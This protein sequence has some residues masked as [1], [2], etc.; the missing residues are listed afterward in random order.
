M[1]I[2]NCIIGHFGFGKNLLNGQ[3][4]K[5]KMITEQ[6]KKNFGAENTTLL[7]LAGG[8]K[9]IPFFLYILPKVMKQNDNIVIMPVENGLMFLTPLLSILNCHRKKKIHYVVIGGWLPTFLHRQKWLIVG[10][11]KFYAIYVETQTMKSM[12]EE[13]GFNNIYVLPNSKDLKALKPE[14][15]IYPNG[16]PYR[17]CTFSRVM[18]EKGIET[19]IHAL[20]HVN[21][22]LGYEA[23]SLDIYGQVWEEETD[24]FEN[25]KESLPR[26]VKYRGC[27]DAEKSVDIL[28]TYFALLF[29]THFF[30]E[31]IP[32][33]ILDAYSAGIP[34]ISAR[35]ES[36]NDVVDEGI[37]GIGYEFNS[38]EDLENKLLLIAN[39]P[40]SIIDLKRN[41]V[42][43]ALL[44]RPEDA[45]SQLMNKLCGGGYKVYPFRLCTFSRVMKEKGI[46]DAIIAVNRV[47]EQ[48]GSDVLCLDIYGQIWDDYSDEFEKLIGNASRNIKYCGS[49]K[50]NESVKVLKDYYALLFPTF[51]E[52]EGFAG[53]IL[54]SLASGLPV[55]ASDW[56]YNGEIVSD[57]IGF[58]FPAHDVDGLVKILSKIVEN[59]N[60]IL[61]RK[62]NC[63]QEFQKY[64]VENST[65]I[66][67]EQ[68]RRSK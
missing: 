50:S 14:E 27:I 5:T 4:I 53:T 18:K 23:F 17:L 26:F 19:A 1:L 62:I 66:L 58:V 13:M 54:D 57:D 28:K 22:K 40:K 7:D 38:I 33:T 31:G 51:Y 8:A 55:I 36:F 11:K 37:T 67:I 59:P 42:E 61:T 25:L 10:L 9:R 52:G 39:N 30:T 12:L 35:W 68:L 41:C 20:E 56:R 63:L 32:G 48:Y 6:I 47:N 16:I 49:V 24:W 64:T 60:L 65:G 29:P 34:V 15:L 46:E 45:T 2:K 43:K 21:E 44:F 3:T